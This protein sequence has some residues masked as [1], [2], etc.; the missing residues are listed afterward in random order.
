MRTFN[1]VSLTTLLAV[2]LASQICQAQSKA[3]E[4]VKWPLEEIFS[5][6]TKHPDWQ[7][8][9]VPKG[10]NR[11][12]LQKALCKHLKEQAASKFPGSNVELKHGYINISFKTHKY[13][14]PAPQIENGRKS[15]RPPKVGPAPDGFILSVGFEDGVGQLVRPQKLKDLPWT[16]L[17]APD[18][19][20]PELKLHLPVTIQYGSETR[21]RPLAELCAPTRWLKS[22]FEEVALWPHILAQRDWLLAQADAK[23]RK[24]LLELA[25]K[26]PHLKNA[27]GWESVAAGLS[28]TATVCISL[29]YLSPQKVKTVHQPLPQS[30]R[31]S[32]MVIIQAPSRE[33][34][35]L[36]MSPLYPNLCLVGQIGTTAADSELDAVLKGLVADALAPLE[37][38]ENSQKKLESRYEKSN[39]KLAVDLLPTSKAEMYQLGQSI[40][41]EAKL[42][43]TTDAAQVYPRGFGMTSMKWS[44]QVELITPD[45]KAW[46]AEAVPLKE[47]DN[48][49]DILLQPGQSLTIGTWDIAKLEYN[50]GHVFRTM[51]NARRTAFSE[52]A[53]P[54]EYRVRWWDG[55]IQGRPPLLSLPFKFELVTSK[56]NR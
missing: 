41:V 34:T 27:R 56:K 50:P 24:D 4:R 48:Y 42:Q 49:N 54:G 8:V 10:W 15:W 37:K 13:D 36:K 33:L 25:K 39:L 31:Y 46:A 52:F 11:N 32:I 43:N 40:V 47:F 19:Y 45:G 20:L 21:R 26:Y 22:I 28:D 51:P 55:W 18:I 9:P 1:P 12:Y 16:I 14:L 5:N 2:L 35:Q 30:E 38:L 6:G 23:I 29:S 7:P 17:L 53:Q 3:P 44:C